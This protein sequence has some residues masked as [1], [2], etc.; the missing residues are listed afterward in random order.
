MIKE[1]ISSQEQKRFQA[2]FEEFD[3]EC[4]MS[5]GNKFDHCTSINKMKY[6]TSL[7]RDIPVPAD[8]IEEAMQEINPLIRS[9][10]G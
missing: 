3:R 9:T 10:V 2:G 4:E 6:S 5:M 1:S 7:K 8:Q